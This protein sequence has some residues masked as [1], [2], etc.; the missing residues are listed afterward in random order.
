MNDRYPLLGL[1][2]AFRRFSSA[3]DGRS[4]FNTR[5]RALEAA[6]AGLN[7]APGAVHLAPE[8]GA[9]ESALEADER[10]ALIVLILVSLLALQEGSTRFPVTGPLSHAPMRRV[11]GTLC[12]DGFGPGV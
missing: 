3:D 11:L 8:L 7:L 2:T 6:A 10:V 1:N 9:L 5:L 12:G 4:T